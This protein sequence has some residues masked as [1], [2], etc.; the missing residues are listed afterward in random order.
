MRGRRVPVTVPGST[1]SRIYKVFFLM[2]YSQEMKVTTFHL[3]HMDLQE[4]FQDTE[5]RVGSFTVVIKDE[6]KS[7]PRIRFDV[8]LDDILN[9]NKIADAILLE[10][11]YMLVYG[12]S[13]Q[14]RSL[15]ACFV[16]EENNALYTLADK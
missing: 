9:L 13:E 16:F 7:S 2:F 15:L 6:S 12:T 5:L 3:Q 10:S 4:F 8:P 14:W 1:R 11:G